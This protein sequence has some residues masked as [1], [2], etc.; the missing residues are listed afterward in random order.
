MIR[1]GRRARRLR[2]GGAHMYVCTYDTSTYEY[3]ALNTYVC[4]SIKAEVSGGGGVFI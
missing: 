4:S 2:V 3:F 1:A